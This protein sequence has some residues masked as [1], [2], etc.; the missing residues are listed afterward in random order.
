MVDRYGDF[1]RYKRAL[2]AKTALLWF[3]PAGLLLGGVVIIAVIVR[4]RRV[5]RADNRAELSSDERERL[6]HLLDKTKND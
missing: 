2:T 6:D 3:G 5:Q 1:V 4:R